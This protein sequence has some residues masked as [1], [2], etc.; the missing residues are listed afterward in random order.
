[1]S[2]R[3][4]ESSPD[5][6][7]ALMSNALSASERSKSELITEQ[8]NLAVFADRLQRAQADGGF[9]AKEEAERNLEETQQTLDSIRRRAA[10]IKLLWDTL[11][12]QR[13]AARKTY[14]RPLKVA[15]ERLGKIVFGSSFEVEIGDDWALL[16][17]TLNGITLPFEYLS[18]GAREQLGILVRLAAAQI[19]AKHGGVPLIIDDALGFSDPTRLETV[20]AAIAAAGKESQIIILTCTPGRFTHVGSAKVVRF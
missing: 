9:E 3:L 1:M 5:S 19:V 15:V 16:T 12:R 14:V 20:G 4:D 7:E 11:N 13:D 2:T 18:V 17:R 8:Q 6:V 10:A